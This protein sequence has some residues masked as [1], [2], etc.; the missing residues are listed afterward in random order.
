M[1]KNFRANTKQ[2]QRFDMQMY[3]GRIVGI[4]SAAEDAIRSISVH[5]T[6]PRNL[7]I[8][9][10]VYRASARSLPVRRYRPFQQ[11]AYKLTS[12]RQSV[13][14]ALPGSNQSD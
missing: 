5:E 7:G 11:S 1:I 12:F 14:L 13:S 6:V 3:S 4:I 10:S 8:I 2:V 9:S